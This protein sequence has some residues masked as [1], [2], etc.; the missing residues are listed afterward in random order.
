MQNLIFTLIFLVVLAV[1]FKIAGLA[2]HFLKLDNYDYSPTE[3]QFI[4]KI[5]KSAHSRH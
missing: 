3:H 2:G 1:F 4:K 5:F